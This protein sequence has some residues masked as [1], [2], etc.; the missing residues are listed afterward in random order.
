MKKIIYYS[1]LIAFL[2]SCSQNTDKKAELEKLKTQHDQLA[3][4]I[5]QLEAEINPE[6]A[7]AE[8]KAITV[9]VSPSTECVFNHYIQVQGTVDG[10]QNIAVSPQM[11]GI[12]TGVYV[13]EGSPVKKGQVM[14]DLD[15]QV[16]KQSLEEVNTQLLLVN[17]IYEKQSALWDKKIGSEIQYLQAKNNKESLEKRVN[18]MKEQLKL[19]KII[20]PISGTVESVP[21]RVGQMASPG[22]PTSTIRVINMNVAKISADVAETYATRIKD[23]NACLVNFPDLG[24]DIETKLNFTSRFIDPTNRTFKVECRVSSKDAELRANMIAYIKI[25]D[26]TNEKAFCIPVNYIQSNQ[27]GKFIYIAKQ[28]GNQ[29]TAERR[30]VKTGMDYDGVIEVLEG[31]T[32][33]ENIITA[34]FQ[35]LNP[36]EIVVF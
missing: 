35:N 15:A 32:A 24:K 5:A 10:D 19:A 16:L 9:K 8:Q 21:L 7:K 25:K 31:L 17:S 28:N 18:T 26:Y 36:G 14:A 23:G 1:A 30:M 12:V 33:G 2:V 22:M 3:T 20:S 13:T 4:Q 11:S 6:G 34:G 27:D 29:W